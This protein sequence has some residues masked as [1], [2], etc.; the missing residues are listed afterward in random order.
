[1][2]PQIFVSQFFHALNNIKTRFFFDKCI[3]S[4]VINLGNTKSVVDINIRKTFVS[5]VI[6]KSIRNAIF[7]LDIA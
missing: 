3:Q 4:E 6:L 7:K 1:M 2:A 5:L